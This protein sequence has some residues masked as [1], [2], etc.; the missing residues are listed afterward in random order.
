MDIRYNYSDVPTIRKFH[1]CDSFIRALMGPFGSGKSS[2]CVV[3]IVARSLA[4]TPSPLDGIKRSR[5]AIIRNTFP[6]LNDTTIRT[7]QQWLPPGLFGTYTQHNHLYK[8]TRFDG[9]EIELMFRALDRPDHVK[10][11]L[12]LELTGA[13][14]NEAR[15]VPW[16]II[17]ALQGRVG[18]YPAVRD[19][20]CKWAGIIMDTNP[21][22]IDSKWYKFFEE[23]NQPEHLAKIFKQPSGLSDFA[24]NLKNLPQDYYE[25]LAAGKEDEWVKVYVKGEYGFVIDGKPVYG[26]FYSDQVHCNENIRTNIKLPIIRGWDFG[27]TP[28]CVFTQLLPNG[29]WII[30]DELVSESMGIDR[31]SDEVIAHCSQEYSDYD[32][33]DY[34]DPAGTE[35][36]QT[37]EKTCYE[38]LHSKDIDIQPGLQTMSIRLE[39]VRKP[40]RTLTG[41]KPQ[42]QLHPRC[43]MLRKGFQ[44]GYQYRRMQ[45]SAERYTNA[46]DKNMYSHPHDALQYIATRLFGYG[47]T[48]REDDR[49]DHER[50]LD[51]NYGSSGMG[52]SETTGY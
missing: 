27:L 17:E 28:S 46:P 48:T 15:E 25:R 30:F 21:P 26:D 22:D 34:G 11:L 42:F 40:L 18:R 49:R 3:E 12:S 6:Q 19:G 2:G 52:R 45:T 47:L 24:E 41:G 35:R 9:T 38:I 8:I 4:Q 23:S 31:F 36:A 13:W 20:G 5:W 32:F 16:A 1:N 50:D 29:Q 39:S 37:D 33:E 14:V 44:G 7:V 10:N 43:K 51:D